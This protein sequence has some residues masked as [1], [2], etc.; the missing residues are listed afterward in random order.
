MYRILKKRQEVIVKDGSVAMIL[1]ACV[2]ALLN[3]VL[4][5][6]FIILFPLRELNKK[7]HFFTF[8]VINGKPMGGTNLWR[9]EGSERFILNEYGEK[10]IHHITNT[11]NIRDELLSDS[12]N[13]HLSIT[14][15]GVGDLDDVGNYH[16]CHGL[17]VPDVNPAN[18]LPMVGNIDVLGNPYGIDRHD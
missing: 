2:F 6:F 11:N 15:P 8:K 12:E 16:G 13:P 10:N 5:M 9:N 7:F 18:G 1:I 14:S 4:C 3:P 17:H